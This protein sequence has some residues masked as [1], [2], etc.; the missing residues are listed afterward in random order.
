M[1][2]NIVMSIYCYLFPMCLLRKAILFFSY[3]SMFYFD[4]LK[5]FCLLLKKFIFHRLESTIQRRIPLKNRNKTLKNRKKNKI[6]FLKG[7]DPFFKPILVIII[8]FFF[9]GEKLSSGIWETC[10]KILGGYDYQN[11]P[12]WGLIYICNCMYHIIIVII[13]KNIS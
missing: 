7:T 6:A 12:K 13:S 3:S 11:P 4:S 5:G 8:I 9:M 10:P 2:S 1:K